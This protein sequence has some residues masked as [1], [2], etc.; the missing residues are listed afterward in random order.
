MICPECGSVNVYI[1][2]TRGN[3][4]P[5]VQRRR[6][7]EDCRLSFWTLEIAYPDLKKPR[8]TKEEKK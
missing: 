1:K 7:C 3:D 8:K 5:V 6:L 4:S 2:E